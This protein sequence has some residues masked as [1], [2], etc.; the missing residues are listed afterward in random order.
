MDVGQ[1]I[2]NVALLFI[3]AVPGIILR[4]ADLV[5]GGFG[6]GVSNLVLFIANTLS[7]FLY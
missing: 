6:K 7:A 5:P 4:K 1:L 3:M 2:F